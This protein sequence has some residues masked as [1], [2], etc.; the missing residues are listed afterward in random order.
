MFFWGLA[1]PYSDT[2]PDA[3]LGAVSQVGRCELSSMLIGHSE[4]SRPYV[5]SMPTN[6]HRYYGAGHSPLYYYRL[7]R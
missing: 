6:L 1:Y 4:E 3:Q 5:V 7:F 2:T